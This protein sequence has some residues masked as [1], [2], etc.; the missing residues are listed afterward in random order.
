M[1][2]TLLKEILEGIKTLNK[3]L[4]R[5]E[6]LIAEL[7]FSSETPSPE[8]RRIIGEYRRELQESRIE[9]TGFE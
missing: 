6:W 2:E 3:R 4:F 1:S 5:L 7:G 8:E 9:F